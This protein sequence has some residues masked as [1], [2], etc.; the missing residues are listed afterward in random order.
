MSDELQEYLEEIYKLPIE[1][2]QKE[3][4]LMYIAFGNMFIIPF[5]YKKSLTKARNLAD[6]EAKI[7]NEI[8]KIYKKEKNRC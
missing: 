4:G 6:A 2:E 1:V 8:L 5:L 7:D 3:N